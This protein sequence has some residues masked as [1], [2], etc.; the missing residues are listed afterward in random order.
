MHLCRFCALF[1]YRFQIDPRRNIALGRT[2]DVSKLDN[3]L[4][5]AHCSAPIELYLVPILV[6][7]DQDGSA[8]QR[9][10]DNRQLPSS[11]QLDGRLV[12]FLSLNGCSSVSY[13]LSYIG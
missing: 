3:S 11:W 5:P 2:D 8:A 1:N 9:Y 10:G 12:Q 13:T 6:K 7:C 4:G